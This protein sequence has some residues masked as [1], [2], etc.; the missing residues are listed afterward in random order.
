MTEPT[1]FRAAFGEIDITPEASQTQPV[2][3]QGLGGRPRL[4]TR[5]GTPLKMQ[6]LV[7]E[8]VGGT[9]L[10]FITADLLGFD[11]Q[12]VR[13]IERCAASWGLAPEAIFLNASHTH[14]GPGVLTN[15]PD[16]LGQCNVKYVQKVLNQIVSALPKL[17]GNLRQCRIQTR[18]ADSCI[19]M[20][21]RLPT[22]RGVEFGPNPDGTVFRHTPILRIHFPKINQSIVMVN[23]GCH[24][25]G[26]GAEEVLS[27]DF[28]H[29]LRE[30]L[31][32]T[33][34]VNAVMFLQ[35]ASGDVKEASFD[36]PGQFAQSSGDAKRAG[37]ILARD[38]REALNHP[39]KPVRGTLCATSIEIH[40][41]LGELPDPATLEQLRDDHSRP[42]LA[43]QWAAR[44]LSWDPQ[45]RSLP[46]RLQVADIGDGI[47]LAG[48]PMEPVAEMGQ[49]LQ[50]ALGPSRTQFVLGCTGPVA[51][52]LPT[53]QM[54]KQGGYECQTAPLVYL[55]PH[56]S[57]GSQEAVLEG[58]RQA[59]GR[60]DTETSPIYGGTTT[61]EAEGESFF[62]LSSGRC[63]TQT[64][65]RLLDFATN[66]KVWHHP[67][68][69]LIQE[70]LGAWL[71]CIDPHKTFWDSR[72]T[73][74]RQ[75]WSKG[76]IHGETDMNMTPFAT[77]I[78]QD[79]PNARFLVLVRNPAG[80][81]R[82][83][84][85][86]GY[87]K[88]HP[89]DVGRL[90]PDPNHPS[91]KHW[92]R[93]EPFE[94]VCWLW[95]ETYRRILEAR[96]QIGPDRVKIVRFE[97]LVKDT[98]L[99]EEVFEFLA[100]EG[101]DESAAAEILST[102]YNEQ[103]SGDFPR[104]QQWSDSMRD[105]L[106]RHCG[107]VAEKLG[108]K[109]PGSGSE[110]DVRNPDRRKADK[111]EERGTPNQ[112]CPEI[113]VKHDNAARKPKL[114][115]LELPGQSTGGHLD[116]VVRD[117]SDRYEIEYLKSQSLEEIA[118]WVEWSEVIW[119]EWANAMAIETTNKLADKLRTRPVFC[120]LHGFEAFTNMPAKINWQ[121]VDRL[122]FVARHKQEVFEANFPNATVHKVVLRNGV[123]T[124]RFSIPDGKENTKHLLL[125]GHLNMRKGLPMLVQCYNQL[126][127]Q[128]D[129]FHLT[130]RG[131]WQNPKY[132]LGVM[133]MVDELNL[134][135]RIHFEEKWIDDLDAWLID[136]SHILSFSLE[137]SFHYT[138]G[139]SMA[140]GLKPI[141]H[142]WRES[143]EI[144]PEKYIF[145]DIDGFLQ[146]A[147]DPEYRPETYRNDLFDHGLDAGRQLREID[148]LIRE[149][150]EEYRTP[151]LPAVTPVVS[152]RSS[153]KTKKH[154][155]IVGLKRSGSTIFWNTFR[156]DPQLRCFDEPFHTSL[157]KHVL[158]G[159]D[160]HKGTMR[161][162]FRHP[163]IITHY[164]NPLP[165]ESETDPNL[166]E[167]QRS[168]LQEL[169]R[170]HPNVC[171]DFVR[172]SAKVAALREACPSALIV[173]LVRD[174]RAFATSHLRPYGKWVHPDA[175]K[176]LLAYN[177]W[178]DF[179]QYQKLA[180]IM[181]FHGSAYEQLLQIWKHMTEAANANQPHM[182]VQFE[183]F[184]RNPHATVSAVYEQL[185]I[186]MPKLNY[187]GIHAP[188]PPAR[189]DDPRWRK[190]CHRIGIE[191][192][193]LY[194]GWTNTTANAAS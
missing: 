169:A 24:P 9:K 187:S 95:G 96:D 42:D 83:G 41:P 179:W 105:L 70:T 5:V 2:M 38:V 129:S 137:E 177:G 106:W 193:Q 53:D 56:L 143:R 128:D 93:W 167:R 59:A 15:M 168:Y 166:T 47:R 62:V 89:W 160:N 157:D 19:G 14:Y 123:D 67:Q 1:D 85:R 91:A 116:H 144:W 194:Q 125:F 77:T 163:D 37:E 145:N 61:A 34:G 175:E 92:H 51:G 3:L 46:M 117:L 124:R 50:E 149:V 119:L 22:N 164:W 8:D 161:E 147:M 152:R 162:Y 181:G 172:A 99:A 115:F 108:Y 188:N 127:K 97:D 94:K 44:M 174:P 45:K 75:S 16:S 191:D 121:V 6:F 36:R 23:H 73:F 171:M 69:Y 4:A 20:N 64:L 173:H 40:L 102:R 138:I 10:L 74:L 17:M 170:T 30:S 57:N 176:D 104:V 76:L 88:G 58:T 114:L 72:E 120:R 178:F 180:Q 182:T 185:D 101:F 156:Q 109:R 87:Y 78:A 54:L 32:G 90:R 103:T 153:G 151:V 132:R 35:G 159:K 86:R 60:L 66:A 48:V 65:S 192:D 190:A 148:E 134:H 13:A 154:L 80:F 130:I 141:I 71:G 146:A 84:M 142:A 31:T 126:L 29:Y 111:P 98:S 189:L 140:A 183:E 27:A 55:T 139:N 25:T 135:D 112:S 21:R 107:E 26:L 18:I 49:H 81:V 82:S 113:S 150:I 33:G 165:P 11:A 52:Y 43:R 39:L 136:K 133:T 186:D 12:V 63:G 122:I 131:E 155:M 118:Q 68:P 184:A 100:L 79:L 28:P 110:E 7:L 158:S